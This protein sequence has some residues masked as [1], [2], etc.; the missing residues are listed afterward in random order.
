M[1]SKMK[2]LSEKRILFV[3]ILKNAILPLIGYLGPLTTNILLGSFAIERVFGIPGLGQWF[4]NGIMNRDYP[5]IGALTLF[6]SVFLLINH[7]F[8]DVLSVVLNPRLTLQN[9]RESTA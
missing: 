6:Y 1:C 4:V 7:L 9:R 2:G 8:F 3:H 5:V